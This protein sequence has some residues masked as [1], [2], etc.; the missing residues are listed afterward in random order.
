MSRHRHVWFEFLGVHNLLAK[1]IPVID[2]VRCQHLPRTLSHFPAR[3]SVIVTRDA[4]ANGN[5]FALN[6]FGIVSI[7]RVELAECKRVAS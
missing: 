5:L 3:R 4:T 6:N 7:G 2:R 1:V